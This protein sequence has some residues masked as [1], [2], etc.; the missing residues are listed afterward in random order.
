MNLQK[1]LE[2]N[3]EML[4]RRERRDRFV[5]VAYIATVIGLVL[6]AIAAVILGDCADPCDTRQ[7]HPRPAHVEPAPDPVEP[8]F[9]AN[10]QPQVAGRGAD[11]APEVPPSSLSG[12]DN[13]S[14]PRPATCLL[15]AIR[16]EESSGKARPTDGDGG[17]AIGPYQIHRD[18]WF[19]SR[20]P[21]RYADCRSEPYARRVVLAYF[22]RYE[23]EALAA[24]DMEAL[25]RLHNGGPRWR[26]RPATADYWRRVRKH[27][28]TEGRCSA[29]QRFAA[30]HELSD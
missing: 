24:G 17:R 3:R 9:D 7:E 30:Q 10:R 2:A 14:T 12:A 6:A 13:P 4:E 21:G 26:E 29:K 8:F 25:A 16:A 15:A 28:A 23:P 20:L 18:Y 22:R 1:M 11:A 27:L 19:D 5:M